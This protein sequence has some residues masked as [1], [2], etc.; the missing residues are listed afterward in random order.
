MSIFNQND[1]LGR[2]PITASVI[3]DVIKENKDNP[4]TWPITEQRLEERVSDILHYIYYSVK[5]GW[6]NNYSVKSGWCNIVWAYPLRAF[7]ITESSPEYTYVKDYLRNRFEEVGFEVVFRESII[8]ISIAISHEYEVD[9]AKWPKAQR[10]FTQTIAS[11]L[12]PVMPIY[13]SS[14]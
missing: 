10:V 9:S 14:I 6:C 7:G 4:L 1:N 13:P 5:S 3:Q 12:V 2:C 11:H 8:V